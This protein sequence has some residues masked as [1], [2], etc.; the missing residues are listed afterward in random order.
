MDYS[1]Q[2]WVRP[3]YLVERGGEGILIADIR[4]HNT[5]PAAFLV[6]G[7]DPGLRFGRSTAAT[8]QHQVSSAPRKHPLGKCQP[9]TATSTRNQI[10]R[11]MAERGL[12]AFAR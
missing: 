1:P 5:K 6:D 8:Q 11:M 9:E 10:S 2:G 12:G 3:F 7:I 4:L